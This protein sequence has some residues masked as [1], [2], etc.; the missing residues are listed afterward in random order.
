MFQ[1]IIEERTSF[2][3]EFLRAFNLR[4]QASWTKPG[5]LFSNWSVYKKNDSPM[6]E[7]LASITINPFGMAISLSNSRE[8]DKEPFEKL[9]TEL[10]SRYGIKVSMGTEVVMR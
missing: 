1:Q 8:P 5:I 2:M 6:A 9:V 7:S 10:A 4:I 3:Q